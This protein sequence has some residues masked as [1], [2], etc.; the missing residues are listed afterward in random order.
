M[1]RVIECLIG[2]LDIVTSREFAN[3]REELA[4]RLMQ[5]I[6]D[7]YNNNLREERIVERMVRKIN[8]FQTLG[9]YFI[10]E[11]KSIFVHGGKSQVKFDYYGTE[12]QVELGDMIF[13]LDI[14]YGGFKFFE[15]YTINQVKKAT[16]NTKRIRWTL[17][18]NSKLQAYLLSRFPSFY[19]VSGVVPNRI[20][21]L[22]NTFGCLGTHGLL[23]PPGDFALV[24]SLHL[25]TILF[26]KNIIVFSD[27]YGALNNHTCCHDQF[28]QLV[29][30]GIWLLAREKLLE[31]WLLLEE[32]QALFLSIWLLCEKNCIMLS[33]R[34]NAPNA[35]AFTDRYLR[36]QAGEL[37][38]AAKLYHNRSALSFLHDILNQI[39]AKYSPT[40]DRFVDEYFQFKYYND[41]TRSWSSSKDNF[42]SGD[43]EGGL[44]I[45]HTRIHIKGLPKELIARYIYKVI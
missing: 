36:G 38:Y 24:S 15:T 6:R 45:V 31:H 35:H 9:S 29:K 44:G 7:G 4:N 42:E 22:C 41:R 18:G 32:L 13:I 1:Q 3:H 33:N 37:V 11:T 20:Y 12:K 43:N 10:L 17:T 40:F 26:S 25:E 27:L 16:N 8:N 34:C 30:R 39:R 5:A 23:F 2:Y 21:S 28:S 19:S 14:V